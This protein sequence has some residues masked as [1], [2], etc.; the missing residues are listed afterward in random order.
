MQVV[1][2]HKDSSWPAVVE[3]H[4]YLTTLLNFHTYLWFRLSDKLLI[5][6]S[7]AP[8][9]GISYLLDSD[10]QDSRCDMIEKL[11]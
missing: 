2:L 1:L 9:G 6:V 4:K 5:S 11:P 3:A 10:V 8:S 7:T